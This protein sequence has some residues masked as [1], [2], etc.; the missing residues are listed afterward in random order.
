MTRILATS[1]TALTL[2]HPLDEFYAQAGLPLPPIAEVPAGSVPQPYRQLLVHQSD[3]TPTLER[4]HG[5]KIHLRLL[6]K[7]HKGSQYFREVVLLLDGTNQPVEFG[8]IKI[9]L[10][11]F[12][13]EAQKQIL[14][15]ER[16]LGHIMEECAV[17]HSSQPKAFFRLATDQVINVALGVKGA[18]LLFGRRNTLFDSQNEPMAEIVEI[19]P[20][21]G[22]SRP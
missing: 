5:R 18:H 9:N 4:F 8:A 19:L 21:V 3:M 16:P 14:Q 2:A 1:T 12:S 15:E 20:P 17:R 7:R 22:R 6:G 11:R 13:T 10:S